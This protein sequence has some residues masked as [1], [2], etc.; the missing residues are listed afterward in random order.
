MFLAED[1]V[2]L[3]LHKTGCT[4]IRDTLKALIPGEFSGKHNQVPRILLTPNTKTLG[5]IRN[6]WDWYVSLWAYG[7]GQKGSI[8]SKSTRK[9]RIKIRGNGWR[10]S[11][12]TAMQTFIHSIRRKPERWLRT[13][14]DA[15]DPGCF[16]EWLQMINDP[17]TFHDIGEGYGA[18]S[19][20]SIAGVL[21]YRFLTLFC[22]AQGEPMSEFT[23]YS[24]LENF[25]R[26]RSFIDYFIRNENLED[27]L[28]EALD[29]IGLDIS[30]A[31]K[32]ATRAAPKTN[33]SSRKRSTSYYYDAYSIDLVAQRDK[34][35]VD[36]FG[37]EPDNP[38]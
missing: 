26:D 21:T 7:C 22:C 11:P 28:F 10:A 35:I 2:F 4:H 14:A 5:S 20:S 3:E 17:S 38:N 36:K 30:D 13:Y 16:R 29:S 19:V 12:A 32:K 1:L 18:S 34:L 25:E 31:A 15:N 9:H 33:T 24:D 27:D 23:D 37:Y 6:P 8:Y